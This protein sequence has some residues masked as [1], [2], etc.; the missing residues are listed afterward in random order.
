MYA[1]ASRG[2]AFYP[3][4][5]K[6]GILLLTELQVLRPEWDTQY[7]KVRHGPGRLNQISRLPVQSRQIVSTFMKH[8]E[9]LPAVHGHRFG[10]C[11]T[12]GCGATQRARAHESFHDTTKT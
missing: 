11:Q 4:H 1:W 2:H 8:E 9:D 7:V 5:G 3:Y 6:Y 12:L 10:N